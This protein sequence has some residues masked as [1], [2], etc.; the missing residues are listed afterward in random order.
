MKEY[1]S[2]PIAEDSDDEKKIYRAQMRAERK[3]KESNTS[4]GYRK[5]YRFTPYLKKLEVTR[6]ETDEN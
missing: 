3:A 2:N 1:E 4:M 5:S 6:M